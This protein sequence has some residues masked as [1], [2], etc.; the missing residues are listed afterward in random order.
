M[1]C[2]FPWVVGIRGMIN[3]SQ[4]GALLEFLDIP[5]KQWGKAVEQSVLSSV[6]AMHFMDQVRF[7]GSRM[8]VLSGLCQDSEN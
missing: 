5:K 4:I 7:G 1:V 6:W 3:P 2:V 8:D